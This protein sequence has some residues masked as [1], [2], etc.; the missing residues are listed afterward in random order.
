MNAIYIGGDFT[1][2]GEVLANH[3]ARIDKTTGQ[4]TSLGEGVQLG[5]NLNKDDI[6]WQSVYCLAIYNG[7]LW[8]G[9]RF[10]SAGEVPRTL[11]LARW[12]GTS[13]KSV[14]ADIPAGRVKSLFV[15][16]GKLYVGGEFSRIANLAGTNGAAVWNGS[17]WS[18]VGTGL[19]SGI[20]PSRVNSFA[21][22]PSGVYLGGSFY[23]PNGTEQVSLAK[24][25]GN[26]W[27]EV[28]ITLY[29]QEV[30]ALAVQGT[31]LLIGHATGGL[32]R[33]NGTAFSDVGTTRRPG[34]RCILVSGNDVYTGGDATNRPDYTEPAPVHLVSLAKFNGT[35]WAEPG[36]GVQGTVHSLLASGGQIYAAGEFMQAGGVPAVRIA[37]WNGTQWSPVVSAGSGGGVGGRVRA[38]LDAGNKIYVGGDFTVAGGVV[39]NRIACW[40]KATRTWSA[41]GTGMRGSPLGLTA[42]STVRALAM[43]GN[44]LYAGGNFIR[45]GGVLC[46]NIA[47]WNGT[48][49]S[50]MSDGLFE[51]VNTML[52]SG[53]DLYVGG[54]FANF[55]RNK[56]AR[57]NGSAWVDIG[58]KGT[59][60]GAEVNALCM[61]G[62][63]LHASV[64]GLQ[65]NGAFGVLKYTG[66]QWVN[67]DVPDPP[68]GACSGLST[69]GGKLLICVNRSGI[70]EWDGTSLHSPPWRFGLS[71]G[72]YSPF[73]KVS[74]A[75]VNGH[76]YA[77]GAD[78]DGQ[79]QYVEG[80]YL[81]SR[82]ALARLDGDQWVELLPDTTHGSVDALTVGSNGSDLYVGGAFTDLG[83]KLSHNLG[84]YSVGVG[85]PEIE[86]KSTTQTEVISG[87]TWNFG[88]VFTKGSVSATFTLKNSGA[89]V[90]YGE[91]L[92]IEGSSDSSFYIRTQPGFPIWSG[93][94]ATLVLGFTPTTVG[95]KTAFLKIRTNDSD[96]SEFQLNLTGE[97]VMMTPPTVKTA[98][99]SGVS[100]DAATLHGFVNAKNS[101]REVFFDYGMTTSYGLSAAAS[102][103]TLAGNDDAAVSV[104]LTGLQ[105]HTKY[106][107]RVRATGALGAASGT[108]LA[109][110]TLNRA[111]VATVDALAVVPGCT[112]SLPLMDNDIDPDGDQL[113]LAVTGVLSP[114]TAGKLTKAGNLLTFAAAPTFSGQ[115]SFS[116]SVKDAFNGTSLPVTVTLTPS[117]CSID[118]STRAL[119]SAGW[120][121]PVTVTASGAWSVGKSTTWI[122]ASPTSGYGGGTVLVTVLPNAGKSPRSTAIQIGGQ[123]HSITQAGVQQPSLTLPP[124]VPPAIVGG[125]YSLDIPTVNLP[126]TYAAK[127]L[128]PGLT[129]NGGTGK[130]SGRPTKDGK[131]G[132]TLNASNAAGKAAET[133]AFD[134]RVT[135][136]PQEV[137]GSYQGLISGNTAINGQRGSRL[138][139]TTTPLG[140]FSGK[141]ITGTASV[142]LKGMLDID[143]ENALHPQLNL[144]LPPKG[145]P[146]LSLR[147][148]LN[149]ESNTL[150]GELRTSSESPVL[151]GVTGWRNGWSKTTKATAYKTLHN[152][153]LEQPDS[154]PT[155]PQGCGYGSIL[156]ANETTGA[157]AVSGRTADG[158]NFTTSAFV[159]PQGQVLLYQSLFGGKGSLSGV[160][161]ITAGLTPAANTL[162]GAASWFKPV[163]P[164]SPPSK[165]LVYKEGFGPLDLTVE[166][167]AYRPVSA[168]HV[169]LELANGSSNNAELI[170]DRAP[171]VDLMLDLRLYN[172]GTALVNKAVVP[173]TVNKVNVSTLNLTTGAFAGDF[174]LPGV[175][176]AQNRTAIFQGV[177]VKRPAGIAG[178]GYFLIP[179]SSTGTAPKNSGRV[180]LKP[181][182]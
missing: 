39:A 114:V 8:V 87:D 23:L 14:V 137:V 15:A 124:V 38:V 152:F 141:I 67:L 56:V 42:P 54:A 44:N 24:W 45:A 155:L 165:D 159:G 146:S 57:W 104:I 138:E 122:S 46:W 94:S 78:F 52:V 65:G 26:A 19:P 109:F 145:G 127:N 12:D 91:N 170:L 69:F 150:G 51:T 66:S 62:G 100:H 174:T 76:L 75:V 60:A 154:D 168:G 40:S 132:I 156:A 47:R 73:S 120:V 68:S 10:L 16:D 107:F 36:A 82:A 178:L 176:T 61:Y 77:G 171:E 135:E 98:A 7:E 13:W 175:T 27:T 151:A 129:L 115:A 85:E 63:A 133:L 88:T 121:Y 72:N 103:A 108:N 83:G 84:I 97:A 58:L 86:L 101:Q 71:I 149:G 4:V 116:Y 182:P 5:F 173:A 161:N 6:F 142:T 167:S 18:A 22:T 128:P 17:E 1:A 157:V 125:Y 147:V 31:E 126:V 96:E 28:T 59:F 153:V 158:S 37:R 29:L 43:V 163:P 113:S 95:T 2:V 53:S 32:K 20:L 140:A 79:D 172:P 169:V 139:L 70:L 180:M 90:L 166:G 117:T 34:I 74:L 55:E 143:P 89:D 119:N 148:E 144:V 92:Y 25:T 9:G 181:L 3:V 110:T 30:S 131:F 64:S 106:N 93:G 179:E 177:I 35:S 118:P 111:P 162:T 41:L 21:S 50:A 99:P 48:A 81:Y 33:W 164:V 102:P 105:P 134:I 123:N 130:L 160:L 49:W 112:V 11:N 80:N 136:L